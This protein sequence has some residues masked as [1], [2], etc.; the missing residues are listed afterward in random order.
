M[1]EQVVVVYRIHTTMLQE[2]TYVLM[3]LL[4]H[5]ERVVNLIHELFFLRRESVRMLWVDCRERVAL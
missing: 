5:L 3:Q 2:Q 4:A 1:E